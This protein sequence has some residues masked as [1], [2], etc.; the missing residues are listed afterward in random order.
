MEKVGGATTFTVQVGPSTTPHNYN[1]G[2]TVS[3]AQRFADSLDDGYDGVYVGEKLSGAT[4]RVQTGV[5]TEKNYYSRPGSA[6]K[7]VRVEISDPNP[8]EE[9]DR[10]PPNPSARLTTSNRRKRQKEENKL[11]MPWRAGRLRNF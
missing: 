1:R 11:Q 10:N 9:E 7:P 6:Q 5:V 3:R 2:G 4:F 8:C